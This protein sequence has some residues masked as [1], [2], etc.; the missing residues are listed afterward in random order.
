MCVKQ[1]KVIKNSYTLISVPILGF[2]VFLLRMS[3]KTE[4]PKTKNIFILVEQDALHYPGQK[5]EKGM[6]F[7]QTPNMAAF[8]DN[9]L[10]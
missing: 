7:C 4:K 5:R 6:E 1:I 3:R 9:R 2:D 8:S 10:K